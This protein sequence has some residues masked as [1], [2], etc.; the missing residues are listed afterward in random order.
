MTQVSVRELI[1]ASNAVVI[2]WLRKSHLVLNEFYAFVPGLFGVEA[3]ANYCCLLTGADESLEPDLP[4]GSNRA[5]CVTR[6]YQ[7]Y[8]H[9]K[10]FLDHPELMKVQ[11]E[12]GY[13]WVLQNAA[14]SKT[15]PKLQK[16]LDAIPDKV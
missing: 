1:D 2:D 8:D 11:A 14:I 12:A 9:L 4:R 5:W 16:M 3:M 10:K 6:Y 13:Q 15:G 7:I